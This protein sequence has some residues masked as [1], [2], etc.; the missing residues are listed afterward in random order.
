MVL[1]PIFQNLLHILIR[2]NWRVTCA[3][4]NNI[5]AGVWPICMLTNICMHESVQ[6]RNSIKALS[7]K[8]VQ[9]PAQPI[10]GQDID[11]ACHGYYSSI[12]VFSTF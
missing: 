4:M 9:L 7:G 3:F 12:P 11:H 8:T 1:Q 2:D 6:A 5:C 10:S